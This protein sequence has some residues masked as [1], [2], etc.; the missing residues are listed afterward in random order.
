MAKKGQKFMKIS[1]ELKQQILKEYYNGEGGTVVLA[2][3][4]NIS[5]HT[6]D[7]WIYKQQHG[8]DIYKN[9]R[10]GHS[11]HPK[12]KNLTIEDYKE[13]YEILKKYQAFLEARHGKK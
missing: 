11:G 12:T 7:T 10:L 9:N 13:R 8:V 5:F 6:I 3:K 1:N 4:Y 2:R